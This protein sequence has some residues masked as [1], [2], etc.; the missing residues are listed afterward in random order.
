VTNPNILGEHDILAINQVAVSRFDRR[1]DDQNV[2][3]A[4]D[5]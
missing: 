4:V 3:I 5:P 2:V 1:H